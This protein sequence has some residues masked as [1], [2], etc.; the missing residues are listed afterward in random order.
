M[1][2][3]NDETNNVTICLRAASEENRSYG[4]TDGAQSDYL[5]V[6][7]VSSFDESGRCATDG[8]GIRAHREGFGSCRRTFSPS[9]KKVKKNIVVCPSCVV[10]SE[11]GIRALWYYQ[12]MEL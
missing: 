12:Y 1:E 7:T 2:G 3:N 9:H 5:L 11:D 10:L 4:D 8:A 6:E